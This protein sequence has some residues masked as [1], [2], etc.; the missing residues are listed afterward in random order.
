MVG[1]FNL[2]V[3]IKQSFNVRMCCYVCGGKISSGDIELLNLIVSKYVQQKIIVKKGNE[4]F[5]STNNELIKLII[6]PIVI[7]ISVAQTRELLLMNLC[8]IIETT[9]KFIQVLP[10]SEGN[11]GKQIYGYSNPTSTNVSTILVSIIHQMMYDS[12]K[13]NILYLASSIIFKINSNHLFNNGNKRTSIFSAFNILSHFGY[14]ISTTVDKT[15]LI[16]D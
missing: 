2:T 11:I 1:N 10:D 9:H 16:K 5:L 13:C 14:D 4:I 6:S 15:S 7:D 12:T 3:D 8:L